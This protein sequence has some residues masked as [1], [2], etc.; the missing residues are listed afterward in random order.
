MSKKKK[1]EEN[2]LREDINPVAQHSGI[3]F[4]GKRAEPIIKR[5]NTSADDAVE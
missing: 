3:Y 5:C 4:E 2:Q 1:K